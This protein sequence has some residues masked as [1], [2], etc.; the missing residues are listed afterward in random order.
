MTEPGLKVFAMGNL[1]DK[2]E[3]KVLVEALRAENEALQAR[4]AEVLSEK[5]PR[6]LFEELVRDPEIRRLAA[7]E[8]AKDE[9]V[10]ALEA[11]LAEAGQERDFFDAERQKVANREEEILAALAAALQ[12]LGAIRETVRKHIAD[13]RWGR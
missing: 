12:A 11:R 13:A 6:D 7:I 8:Y 10:V 2:D 4:L 5:A 3:V 1:I 9:S